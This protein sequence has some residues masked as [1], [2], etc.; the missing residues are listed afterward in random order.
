MARRYYECIVCGKKFPE[1]QGIVIV[2]SGLTLYFHSNKCASKFLRR[3]LEHAED[4]CIR[5]AL[6]ET[7]DSFKKALEAMKERKRKVI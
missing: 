4:S 3:L 1:G 5:E 6:S 2:K 7:I